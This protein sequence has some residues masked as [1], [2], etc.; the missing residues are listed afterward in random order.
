MLP[1]SIVYMHTCVCGVCVCK[2]NVELCMG[3]RVSNSAILASVLRISLK[4]SYYFF[5]NENCIRKLYA[6][7]LN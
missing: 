4:L 5:K 6:Y 1:K 7:F 2:L 3:M